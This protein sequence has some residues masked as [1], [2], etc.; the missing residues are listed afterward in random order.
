MSL[1]PF[2]F[3]VRT[4]RGGRTVRVRQDARNPRRY[5]LEVQH[6]GGRRVRRDHASLLGALRDCAQSL[7]NA[8]H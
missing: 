7:R 3:G 8:L 2:A 1:R 5:R 6:D 4:R